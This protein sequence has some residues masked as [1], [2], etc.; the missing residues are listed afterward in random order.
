MGTAM[1]NV[2]S[3]LFDW[4]NTLVDYPLQDW[5]EQISFLR[6]FLAESVSGLAPREPR[7]APLLDEFNREAGDSRIHPFRERFRKVFGD[8]LSPEEI[9]DLERALCERIFVAARPFEETIE[10]LR[11]LRR[12]GLKIG[13]VSNAP[14]GSSPGL[15]RAEIERHGFGPDVVDTVVLCGDVGFR[16]PH[17]AI[18]R[19]CL[20]R[21]GSVPEEAVF[22]GDSLASDVAGAQ[23]VGCRPIWLCRGAGPMPPEGVARICDLR[24]L[25]VQLAR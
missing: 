18:F 5:D 11:H 1:R 17:A 2:R 16:K 14:W 8:V 25:A 24:E 15:W 23:A 3:V 22:V 4:G 10:S 7:T 6:E 9:V 12:A 21:L 20:E 19:A 13:I